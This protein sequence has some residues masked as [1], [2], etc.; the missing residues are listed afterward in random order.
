M[1]AHGAGAAT[2][3]DLP[4]RVLSDKGVD[5]EL[6]RA[7]EALVAALGT[8]MP[9][10]QQGKTKHIPSGSVYLAQLMAHDLILSVPDHPT[11]SET[12]P[13]RNGVS[14]PLMLETL[15]GS[16]PQSEPHL[17]APTNPRDCCK[18]RATS[19]ERRTF[20]PV[21]RSR[22]G[23][24]TL[25]TDLP[26]TPCCVGTTHE[27]E[28][29]IADRRN[30]SHA[31]IAWITAQ[32]MRF[33][34][35]VF[36]LSAGWPGTAQA[37]DPAGYRERFRRTQAVVRARWHSVIRTNVLPYLLHPDWQG[38]SHPQPPAMP[39]ARARIALRTLHSLALAHYRLKD[40]GFD[41]LEILDTGSHGDTR[42][43]TGPDWEIRPGNFFDMD[44][45]GTAHNRTRYRPTVDPWLR[46]AP[47]DPTQ[48]IGSGEHVLSA[49]L[50]LDLLARSAPLIAPHEEELLPGPLQAGQRKATITTYLEQVVK[51]GG[52]D[53][54]WGGPNGNGHIGVL[55][56]NPPLALVL[57]LEADR[58]DTDGKSLGRFGSRL[59]APWVLGALR[60]AEASLEPTLLHDIPADCRDTLICGC[61]EG[62]L[63][64]I[65]Q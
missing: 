21:F 49:D 32:W 36:E 48:L 33:H 50:N 29:V 10:S 24:V 16:G 25:P 39:D 52:Q 56:D 4:D 47:D 17:Y 14:N 22:Y 12:P 5:L 2:L 26:R 64:T 60:A 58:G 57:L 34:N 37:D 1:G 63:K 44:G 9:T 65:N 38:G 54:L 20:R 19:L 42:H 15:Y 13:R 31:I 28:T 62:L 43:L 53:L 18:P 51:D 7:Y 35:H 27:Y 61:F 6:R 40:E 30:D 45:P 46:I 59:L 23:V 55:S 3:K 11:R 8:Y 41:L